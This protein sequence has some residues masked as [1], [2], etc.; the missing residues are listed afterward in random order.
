MIWPKS[1]LK[2]KSKWNPGNVANQNNAVKPN[3]NAN[4]EGLP[5][6]HILF[7][8]SFFPISYTIAISFS[9]HF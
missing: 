9:R 8:L 1:K 7:P 3:P 2:S 4:T 6:F 5:S